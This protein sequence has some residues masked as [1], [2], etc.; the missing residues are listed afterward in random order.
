MPS[1]EVTARSAHDDSRR[2]GRRPSR[3]R[4]SPAGSPRR[5]A[6]CRRRGRRGGSRRCRSRRPGAGCR[7]SRAVISPG[8]RIA[9]PGPGNG[10]RPTKASGRPSSRPSARTSSLNSSRSGSTSF[11]FMRSGRPP[12][13]WWHLIVTDGPPVNDTLSITSGI[14]RALREE[15]AGAAAPAIFLASASNT[16][17]NRRADGLA[18]GLRVGDARERLEEQRRGVD[19]D[20]RDVV[21]VAEQRARPARASPRR[22][23]PW[24]TNTQVSW[25]PIASWI[26]TAATAESTPPERPQITLPLADLR[27]DLGDRLVLEGAPWSSRRRSPATS[28]T[29]LRSSVRAV[30]ACAPPRGGTAPRR[31]A[32]PRRRSAANGAFCE[33]ATTGKPGGS[34][35]TRSPWLIQTGY[36]CPRCQTPSNSGQSAVTST[37]ARPNSRWWPP[38]T[39]PPSWW[40][41]GLLA[42]AD[43][44][45]RHAGGIESG[46]GSGAPRS[47]TEAGPPERMIALRLHLARRPRLGLLERHDLAIDALL[48]HAPGDQLGDLGAEIDDQDVV[49]HRPMCGAARAG[50]R[51]RQG[52]SKI[53]V[54]SRGQ[55]PP[56]QRGTAERPATSPRARGEGR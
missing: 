24:S 53:A 3:R 12:T 21:A 45:D 30:R 46:G 5:P 54:P 47:I 23:R 32:A 39:L 19:M 37:S 6:R 55:G 36:F 50:S 29:K 41:H 17:M 22:S 42:V 51:P 35:V 27:A 40:R 28:R 31:S 8:Q 49:V 33:V 52:I 14:E 15:A 13:L 20:Q 43:A 7:A 16:S 4:S 25:S 18:L 1:A 26:S 56:P 9:R 48:A 34:L 11:M 10:W 38:S 2:C 44:E